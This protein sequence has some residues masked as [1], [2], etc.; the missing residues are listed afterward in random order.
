M[1]ESIIGYVLGVGNVEEDKGLVKLGDIAH[2]FIIHSFAAAGKLQMCQILVL[3]DHQIACSCQ[4]AITI[5]E[6]NFLELS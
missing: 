5:R 6:I 2:D 3:V 1:F 4:Q